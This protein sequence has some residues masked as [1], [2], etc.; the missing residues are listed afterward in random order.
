MTQTIRPASDIS[1]GS[2]TPSSGSTLW[3]MLDE[4]AHDDNGTYATGSNGA[5]TF[6]VKLGTSTD[7]VSSVDHIVY[8]WGMAVGSGKG[9]DV[10]V[11]LYESTTLIATISAKWLPGRGTYAQLAYTLLGAEADAIADYTDLRVRVV[12]GSIGGG[13]EFR[14]TQVYMEIPDASAPQLTVANVAQVHALE[15]VLTLLYN[16]TLTP[17]NVAHTHALEDTLTLLYNASLVVANVA[18]AHALEDA[19]ALLYKAVLAPANIAQAHTLEDSLVLL[20]N[21]ILTLAAV[22]HTHDIEDALTLLYNAILTLADVVQ[23]HDVEDT[24]TLVF[25]P[26][27]A[28]ILELASVLH[29]HDID[30]VLTLLYNAVSTPDGVVQ[31]HE[32]D[33]PTLVFHEGAAALLEIVDL[34]HSHDVDEDF[35]LVFHGILVVADVRHK[36]ILGEVEF[37]AEIE[38]EVKKE[39]R[40]IFL[41]TGRKLG[42]VKRDVRQKKLRNRPGRIGGIIITR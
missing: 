32:V 39:T 9:E 38:V 42:H 5:G 31:I 18:Q 15:G 6:E 21:A 16:A 10:V 11:S 33:A 1:A 3:E 19:L 13:E 14:V 7:P 28:E 23:V 2:W 41:L 20:Y 29:I 37:E 12:E 17:A 24:L 4:V 27:G 22:A 40:S 36:H 26:A 35:T 8:A 25:S 30:D 34:V